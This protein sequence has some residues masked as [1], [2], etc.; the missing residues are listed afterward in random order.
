MQPFFIV[1]LVCAQ[2]QLKYLALN[3]CIGKLGIFLVGIMHFLVM[4]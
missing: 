1:I 4:H 2:A 3:R